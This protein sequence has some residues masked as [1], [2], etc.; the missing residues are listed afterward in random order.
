MGADKALRR[1]ASALLA[2]ACKGN[3][4]A[5]SMIADRLDG[6]H[7]GPQRGTSRRQPVSMPLRP[8]GPPMWALWHDLYGSSTS[9]I[10][11]ARGGSG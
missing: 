9:D 3:V 8:Q 10:C 4:A 6:K 1:I 2:G 7:L 11:A 5:A